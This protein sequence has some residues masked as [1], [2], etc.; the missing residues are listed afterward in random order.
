M[1]LFCCLKCLS[2]ELYGHWQPLDIVKDAFLWGFLLLP[3][4]LFGEQKKICQIFIWD[5]L[6]KL[7]NNKNKL[8]SAQSKLRKALISSD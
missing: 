2:I 4:A 6:V 5:P 3:Q 1:E 7:V 8:S